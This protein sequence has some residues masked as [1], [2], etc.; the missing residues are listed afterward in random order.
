MDR[1]IEQSHLQLMTII[2]VTGGRRPIRMMA[3]LLLVA[4]LAVATT[5]GADASSSS[6]STVVVYGATAAGVTAAV[7]AAREG[8]RVVLINDRANVGGMTSGGLGKTDVGLSAVIGGQAA[9]FYEAMGTYYNLSLPIQ[10]TPLIN[11]RPEH[12]DPSARPCRYYAF[13]PKVAEAYLRRQLE[14]ADVELIERE[15][16]VSLE[17]QAAPS[18][19]IAALTTNTTRR[20]AA[21]VFVDATYEGDLLPLAGVS[22][23]M[24]REAAS[25]Y[26]ESL[27]GVYT[28][29]KD[30]PRSA[31]QCGVSPWADAQNKTLIA[32]V[33]PGPV[34]EAGAADS[35]VQ[36]YDFRVTLTNDTANSIPI[37]KPADYDPAQ[38]EYLRRQHAH[39]N[40]Q[41]KPGALNV[42]GGRWCLMPTGKGN[43]GGFSKT[44]L[45]GE[46]LTGPG[47]A[48]DY[49]NASSW[50]ARQV[51]WQ[52]YESY[53]K[54]HLWFL[55][56]DPTVSATIRDAM[57]QWGWPKDEFEATGHFP[58]AMYIREARRLVGAVVMT[59]HDAATGHNLSKNESV[60][61]GSY[62]YDSHYAQRVPCS[63]GG[64]ERSGSSY[65]YGVQEE[66]G[67][68][69][70]GR[71]MFQV[72]R[73]GMKPSSFWAPF[74]VF[75]N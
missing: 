54:G 6:D 56:S 41:L 73:A 72:P 7:S 62:D 12:C 65:Y 60:G 68:P 26:N 64:H 32:S 37:T 31:C 30:Y 22:H 61:L 19:A 74:Y 63:C 24:G 9:A 57:R 1:R 45:N 69:H 16:V 11:V 28:S 75:L 43:V 29:L 44:D 5:H 4:L 14:A 49:P 35:K 17:M 15:H 21:D 23:R 55:K 46:D 52:R 18:T 10:G 59:Q 70:G 67:I 39:G 50:E 40:R 20:I 2:R 27:G 36:A 8:A 58:H 25:E 42:S 38:F 13:E 53:I 33:Q 3:L 34:G 66:G 48:W 47:F 51:I 71:S